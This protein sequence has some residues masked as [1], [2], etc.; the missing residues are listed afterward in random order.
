MDPL[1]YMG[2]EQYEI[3]VLNYNVFLRYLTKKAKSVLN[4]NDAKFFDLKYKGK[5][6]DILRNYIKIN[7]IK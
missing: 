6:F 4:W 5:E 3:N 2:K 7:K 1:L